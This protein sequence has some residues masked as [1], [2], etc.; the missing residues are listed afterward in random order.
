MDLSRA[1]DCISHDLH[2][3]KRH[4]YGLSGYAVT[5]VNSYLKRRRRDVNIN[6]TEGVFQILLSGIWYTSGIY[7][8]AAFATRF[9]K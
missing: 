8:V 1:F 7:L 3:A 4:A 6:D 9:S 2:T 5:F